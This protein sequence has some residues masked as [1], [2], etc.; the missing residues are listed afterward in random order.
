ML[1]LNYILLT[2]KCIRLSWTIL[3]FNLCNN[4]IISYD[5]LILNGNYWLYVNEP[6]QFYDKLV[7][8]R[9]FVVLLIVLCYRYNYHPQ[10]QVLESLSCI[11]LDM[12]NLH[13]NLHIHSKHINSMDIIIKES[14]ICQ[15]ISE[16]DNLSYHV[17]YCTGSGLYRECL[18]NCDH[19]IKY[20]LFLLS[21]RV[22]FWGVPHPIGNTI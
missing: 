16:Q 1:S 4:M 21:S 10:L 5:W 7:D 9:V 2:Y 15:H 20:R 6:V 19:Q 11:L 22:M 3:W 8:I 18:V 17:H 12:V 14:Y 13:N